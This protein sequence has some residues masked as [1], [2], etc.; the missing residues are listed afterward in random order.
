MKRFIIGSGNYILQETKSM[1]VKLLKV[2]LT[3]FYGIAIN[4]LIYDEGKEE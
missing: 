3:I 1:K 4:H 2:N